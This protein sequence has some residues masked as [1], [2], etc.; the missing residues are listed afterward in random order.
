MEPDDAD[1]KNAYAIA[2]ERGIPVQM[3]FSEERPE[4]P[5]TV[6]IEITASDGTETDVVGVSVGGGSIL[7]TEINGLGVEITGE[8]PT[9][10]IPH[11]D[12]PGVIAEVTHVLATLKINIA[13]M[14]SFRHS[15]GEDAYMTIETDQKIGDETLTLIRTLCP[16]L[17]KLF[18]V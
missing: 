9:L 7:I 13:F 2:R 10:I 8:Y 4:Q 17:K 6:R 11:H 18:A 12:E 1:I 5:N 3:E 16:A 15:K 14:R